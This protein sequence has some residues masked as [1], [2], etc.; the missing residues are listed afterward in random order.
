MARASHNV[1]DVLE[2]LNSLFTEAI[3]PSSPL[4]GTKNMIRSRSS[5][6]PRT[7]SKTSEGS[8]ASLA[9]FLGAALSSPALRLPFPF[10]CVN[11][12][13]GMSRRYTSARGE[14]RASR[15]FYSQKRARGRIQN[16]RALLILRFAYKSC[17]GSGR[18]TPYSV[19]SYRIVS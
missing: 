17:C 3:R 16:S 4:V 9:L 18:L 7:S 5:W 6:L 11:L 2:V 10:F 12:S 13:F 19:V 15:G 8:G 1:L 14:V